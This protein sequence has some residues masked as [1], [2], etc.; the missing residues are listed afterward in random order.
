MIRGLGHAALRVGDMEKSVDF[1]TRVLGGEIAMQ[2]EE[3]GRITM[4]YVRLTDLSYIELFA[5]P[6]DAVKGD[7]GIGV[8]HLC[9]AVDDAQAEAERVALLGLPKPQICVGKYSNYHFW[10]KDPD[11]NDIEMM[12]YLPGYPQP[13]AREG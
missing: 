2:G 6:K 9:V 11:G 10:L 12:Q 7:P 8:A 3:N 1:Y 13:T 5:A 4:T